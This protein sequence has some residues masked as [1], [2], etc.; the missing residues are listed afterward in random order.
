ML[1]AMDP[2]DVFERLRSS[3][4]SALEACR[5]ASKLGLNKIAWISG[6]RQAYGLSLLEAKTVLL[7]ESGFAGSVDEHQGAIA[8]MLIRAEEQAREVDRLVQEAEHLRGT[9][10]DEVLAQ[11]FAP[12]WPSRLR[13][14]RELVLEAQAARDIFSTR[15][16]IE[17]SRRAE[18]QPPVVLGF[19]ALLTA[20]GRVTDEHVESLFGEF[21]SGRWVQ[22]F[23]DAPRT[24]LLGVLTGRCGD[25][26]HPQLPMSQREVAERL[27]A[28]WDQP[29]GFFVR[30]REGTF[31]EA[32]AAQ[33]LGLLECL[34][35]GADEPL[36]RG[37]VRQ[38]WFMPV[39]CGWQQ[40]RVAEGG[41]AARLEAFVTRV[42][43]ALIEKLGVP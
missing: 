13:D 21:E 2:K 40:E 17:M 27:G 30:L 11:T 31:D 22:L 8:G 34:D 1:R 25:A 26:S 16:D 29:H 28:Q 9:E 15:R 20:L 36:E 7:R 35:V 41:K 4:C 43:D 32:G 33:V 24:E 42:T 10:V 3:G 12:G 18:G 14:V 23:L 37:L 6:L 38:L 5:V 19:D 39:F